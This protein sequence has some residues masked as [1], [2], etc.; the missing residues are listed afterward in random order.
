MDIINYF[1]ENVTALLL[2]PLLIFFARIFDVSLGTIRIILVSKGY[3]TV[4][5]LF[6][7][8][9]ALIWV[10][11]ASQVMQNLNS[12]FYYVVWAFGFAMGTYVGVIFEQKLSLGQVIVRVIT[13]K[14]ASDLV[15]DLRERKYHLTSVNA[16]GLHGPV[17]LIFMVLKR[18]DM[19][20]VIGTIKDFN[21]NAFYSVED[22]RSVSGSYFKKNTVVETPRRFFNLE[23]FTLNRK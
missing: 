11:A 6:G 14:D 10:T 12:F 22:V 9:E 19:K 20:E 2:I 13:N 1:S 18:V 8:F 23:K 7:F 17:T 5:S 21:P 4:A 15:A 16:E 3:R